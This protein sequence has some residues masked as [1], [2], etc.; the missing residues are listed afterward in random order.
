M[1]PT[2]PPMER[3]GPFPFERLQVPSKSGRHS[4]LT[5]RTSSPISELSIRSTEHITP[6]LL[7][8]RDPNTIPHGESSDA[9]LANVNPFEYDSSLA[10][11]RALSMSTFE[12]DV[13]NS[14]ES[15]R[16]RPRADW[17][18]YTL[19][20][21]Y[22]SSLALFISAL[23]ITI[24]VLLVLSRRNDG[25]G[26][27]DGS[28]AVLF[29]WRFLPTL[30][31]VA[32]AQLT[33][34]LYEDVRRMEPFALLARDT[35]VK[36]SSTVLQRSDAWWT[37][38][39]KS[40]AGRNGTRSWV[41]F[42]ACLLHVVAFLAIAPLSSSILTSMDVETQ[43]D[44]SF[45][46]LVPRADSV[47]PV[48]PEGDTFFRTISNL[49]QNVTTSAWITE[50][51]FV[52]PSWPAATSNAPLR[53]RL[54]D[55]PQIWHTQSTVY[56]VKYDCRNVRIADIQ[57]ITSPPGSGREYETYPISVEFQDAEG[58]SF[59]MDL[60]TQTGWKLLMWGGAFW[61][62]L[63]PSKSFPGK[64]TF[65]KDVKSRCGTN[66][67]IIFLT[68]P[69]GQRFEEA[70]KLRNDT[71]VAAQICNST[72]S[73]A[74]IPLTIDN[75]QVGAQ[76]HITF[77]E[78]SFEQNKMDITSASLNTSTIRELLLDAR[79]SDYLSKPLRAADTAI[80]ASDSS[81][82]DGAAAALGMFYNW[83]LSTMIE[84]RDLAE[85]AQQIQHRLFS[86]LIQ[87]SASQPNVSSTLARTGKI[88]QTQR[89]VVVVP[90]LANA[91]ISLFGVSLVLLLL[92]YRM[93]RLS[94]RPVNLRQDPTTTIGL[95]SLLPCIVPHP[96]LLHLSKAS[97]KDID[98]SLRE[99]KYR[100]MS[101][102][103]SS[104]YAPA[105][106]E[107]KIDPK[108]NSHV[109]LPAYPCRISSKLVF[110]E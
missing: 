77:D 32:Y 62:D 99:T 12:L 15:T 40:L 25:L 87:V 108:S 27:D 35:G 24:I 9:L 67:D 96:K 68:T 16:S 45:S 74:E 94:R 103:P 47:M 42:C 7:G 48:Q 26:A 11:P 98:D 41:L 38:L 58:C 101:N 14:Q 57:N 81:V 50:K 30:L 17:M 6:P 5:S 23:V 63:L 54:S 64:S 34:M 75:S 73:A 4:P 76:T 51:H 28:D 95:A 69:W 31:A 59:I 46:S 110:S 60:E 85:S 3:I 83:N 71:K 100:L 18:P 43:T 82:Y 107:G 92:V 109:V 1:T 104:K 91:L 8:S 72:F 97:R 19:R 10:G 89:R 88:T 66:M 106:D 55:I 90:Q 65:G 102:T 22:M 13:S 2:T 20:W 39:R 61:S 29:G 37:V 56:Q 105:E 49:L 78:A 21:W 79:W 80:P 52:F 86:E 93:T 84:A 36:G 70:Y 44:V 33:S 53:A